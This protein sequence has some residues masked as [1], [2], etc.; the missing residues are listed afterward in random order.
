MIQTAADLY[1][2]S[3]Q[4]YEKLGIVYDSSELLSNYIATVSNQAYRL[5]LSDNFDKENQK[6]LARQRNCYL[7]EI[8]THERLPEIQKFLAV[9][10]FDSPANIERYNA[11]IRSLSHPNKEESE[12]EL[13]HLRSELKRY[14]AENQSFLGIKRSTI[15]LVGNV[16]RKLHIRTRLK[17][18]FQYKE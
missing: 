9:V 4:V 12:L 1:E 11:L 13:D 10:A 2:K 14:I 8:M 17:S 7:E 15:L 6:E 16:K 3:K 18:I 5:V